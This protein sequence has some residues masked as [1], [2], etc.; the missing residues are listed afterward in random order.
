MGGGGI[1]Q[2]LHSCFSP[3]SPRFVDSQRSRKS[4]VLSK[5]MSL[6]EVETWIAGCLRAQNT[7]ESQ[8]PTV[9]LRFGDHLLPAQFL[10]LLGTNTLKRYHD[11]RQSVNWTQI[12]TILW[13][14]IVKIFDTPRRPWKF[15]KSSQSYFYK[16]CFVDLSCRILD[17]G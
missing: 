15:S 1:A 17:L 7:K 3:S 2:R 10:G 9:I 4:P 14:S 12:Q 6:F 8:Q 5:I 11:H 13:S 16:C